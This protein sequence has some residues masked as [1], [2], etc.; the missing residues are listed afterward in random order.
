MMARKEG[1]PA[2]SENNQIRILL[3]WQHPLMV[4]GASAKLHYPD[5]IFQ[6]ILFIFL[7]CAYQ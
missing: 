7:I 5:I 4:R 6:N 2:L 1:N 3:R